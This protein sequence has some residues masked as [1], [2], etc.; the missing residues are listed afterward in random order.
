MDRYPD[1][2]PIIEGTPLVETSI[3]EVPLPKVSLP[4][5]L[6]YEYLGNGKFIAAWF[7]FN[8]DDILLTVEFDGVNSIFELDLE[9]IDKFSHDNNWNKYGFLNFNKDESMIGIEYPSLKSFN[10]SFRVYARCHKDSTKHKLESYMVQ[11]I[12]EN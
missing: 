1:T 2:L 10:K 7:K 3:I 12:K 4:N 11:L 6:L 9:F 8:S 5:T